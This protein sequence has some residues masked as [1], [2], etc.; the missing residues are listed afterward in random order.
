MPSFPSLSMT[1]ERRCRRALFLMGVCLLALTAHARGQD[2]DVTGAPSIKV[3]G[4]QVAREMVEAMAAS[5]GGDGPALTLDYLRAETPGSAA[6]ALA[7]G[8]D[9][10]LTLGEITDRDVSSF[11]QRWEALAPQRH[12]VGVRAVAII[13]HPRNPLDSLTVEQLQAIYSGRAAQWAVLGSAGGSIRRYGLHPTDPLAGM[14]HDRVLPMARSAM[15]LRKKDSAEVLASVKGDPQGVGYVD[16]VLAASAGDAVKVLAVAQSGAALLPNAQT[17]K[18]GTYPLAEQLLLHVPSQPSD[19]AGRFTQMILTGKGDAL[20]RRF[21][22]LPALREVKADAMDAFEKLYRADI[23]RVRATTQVTDD[24]ALAHQMVQSARMMT[25][26]PDLLA[27]LC[28]TAYELAFNAGAGGETAAFEAV[29][30]LVSHVPAKAFDGALKRAAVY[31]RAFAVNQSR[32]E[33]EHLV[34]IL[35][36]AGDLGTTVRQYVR[37]ADAWERGRKIAEE[38]NSPK[39]NVIAERQEAFAAR[40]K[41]VEEATALA[42]ALRQAPTDSQLRQRMLLHQLV[43][44]DHATEASRYLDAARDEVL[45]TNL[46]LAIEAVENLSAETALR[47]AEWYAGL[48][49]Q[50]GQGGAE[51]MAARAKIYYHRFFQM[52]TSYD[53]AL[54]VRAGLGIRRVGGVIPVRESLDIVAA[55]PRGPVVQEVLLPGEQMTDLKLAEFA[56]ANT[57]LT[58]L[59]RREINS[60]QH[61]TDLRPLTRL[62]RLTSLEVHQAGQVKDI[63]PLAELSNLTSLAMTGLVVEDLSA[64][65]RLFR[66][67][68]LSLTG[69]KHVS[70]LTPL[71]R[72]GSLTSLNLSGCEKVTDLA[73]LKGLAGNLVALNLSGCTALKE[74][75]VLGEFRKLKTLDIQRSAVSLDAQDELHRQLTHCRILVSK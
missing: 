44:L 18:D 23:N 9:V 31:E 57:E 75:A 29:R 36:L 71:A 55:A 47:L 26:E 22:F 46:P 17:L 38:L 8:R 37:A 20:C 49:T 65:S 64:L 59:S 13:V 56:A 34:S 32:L 1:L 61:V 42:A 54:A 2:G 67:T 70:D 14:F 7:A 4:P 30:V 48:M 16:A 24:L 52:H 27:I 58:R 39:A 40:V 68:S 21:G 12:V 41:A 43:E 66:L 19:A 50:A 62:N 53:D 45:K 63:A 60:F 10:V 72:L 15:V 25:S 6:G 3:A 5:L 28:E 69:A 51:L 11:R 74:V 33:G 35:M 73:P